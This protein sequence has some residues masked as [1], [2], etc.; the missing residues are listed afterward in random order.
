MGLKNIF[1]YNFSTNKIHILDNSKQYNIS[2]KK[3]N[4]TNKC[5]SQST[6]W[7]HAQKIS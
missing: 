3:K 2:S 6:Y 4:N 5:E 1:I 7:Q